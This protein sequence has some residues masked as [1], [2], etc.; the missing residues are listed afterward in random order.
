MKL[1]RRREARRA[2]LHGPKVTDDVNTTQF[3]A[4]KEEIEETVT[5]SSSNTGSSDDIQESHDHMDL[6]KL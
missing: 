4:E 1:K 3:V 2:A 5:G 6:K